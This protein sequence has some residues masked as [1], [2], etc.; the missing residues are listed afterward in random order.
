MSTA[1]SNRQVVLELLL[2]KGVSE[3]E[4]FSAI[5]SLGDD[6]I[7]ELSSL[8]SKALRA[9]VGEC[10]MFMA[11]KKDELKSNSNFIR[12]KNQVSAMQSDFE[13]SIYAHK[14]TKK[15]AMSLMKAPKTGLKSV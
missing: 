12:L 11:E 13:K 15:L 14:V 6:R 3:K 9:I 8:D 7:K 5:N 2:N 4:A 10:E 1:G